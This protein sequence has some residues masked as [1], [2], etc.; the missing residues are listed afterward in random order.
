MEIIILVLAISLTA[1]IH[2]AGHAFF[3]KLFGVNVLE[4][5]VG[6]GWK[7][8]D[9]DW[10]G[11]IYK[12]SALPLGGY[13]LLERM[14]DTSTM[15]INIPVPKFLSNSDN[16]DAPLIETVY[17]EEVPP[18]KGTFEYISP[19]KQ[20]IVNAGGIIFNIISIYMVCIPYMMYFKDFS[21]LKSI[22]ICIG[23]T[24][25]I[26]VFIVMVVKDI[27]SPKIATTFQGPIEASSIV[28]TKTA[29]LL[30][31]TSPFMEFGLAFFLISASAVV[32]NLLPVP[33]LDGWNMST[34]LFEMVTGR[35]VN[36]KF[37]AVAKIIGA[38][39]FIVLMVFIYGKDL[40]KALF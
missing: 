3:A 26:P 16:E 15:T 12:L 18:I 29:E 14:P 17:G 31:T 25:M 1:A 7:V 11:T 20:F 28:H 40:Y 9:F 5:S 24:I 36:S 37:Q 23:G 35:K 22:S 13:V 27:F 4:F 19:W 10:K 21:F 38:A 6:M 33:P 8:F 39:I 2:E 30:H 34:N 32:M